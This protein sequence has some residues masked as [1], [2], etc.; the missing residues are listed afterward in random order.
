MQLNN[1]CIRDILLYIEA[2]TDFNHKFT[3]ISKMLNFLSYDENTLY[4]HIHMISQADLVERVISGDMKPLK[5]SSLSWEGHQYL[6]NIRDN[7]IW[8]IIKDN[9]SK[10]SSV[11]LKILVS[12]APKI[13]EKYLLNS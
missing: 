5:V 4:Y 6:D 12:L 1:D 13:I 7:K 3:D 8:S 2:N 10:L 9:T 11:S